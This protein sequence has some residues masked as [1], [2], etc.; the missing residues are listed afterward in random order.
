MSFLPCRLPLTPAKESR[1]ILIMAIALLLT[2]GLLSA[3][4]SDSEPTPQLPTR[5]PVPTFTPTPYV[6]QA[7]PVLAPVSAPA[8]A[9]PVAPVEAAP[10]AVV[11]AAP[12]AQAVEPA[13][14]P[15]LVIV[16]S[17]TVNLRSGPGTD[18]A[19]AGQASRGEELPIV[20]RDAAGE[21]FQVCC[22]NGQEAWIAAFL[23][24]TQGAVEG[25]A[26]AQ[27]IPAPPP[28]SIPAPA[29]PTNTPAPAQPTQPPAPSFAFAKFGNVLPQQNSNPYVTF[30]GALFNK[31]AS[32]IMGGYKMVAEGPAGRVE[33]D[34]GTF[35]LHGNPGLESEYIYNVKIEFP[36]ATPG[37]YKVYVT[38]G[39]GNQV[40]EA[41]EYTVAGETRTFLPRWKQN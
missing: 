22:V 24:E 15:A 28:T 13:P 8:E 5:T 40:A 30:F 34:F 16:T 31:D 38:D 36:G 2:L 26:V 18:Y 1:S 3:C 39:G 6:I 35:P 20:A 17:P 7:T 12:T 23:V 32:A 29:A 21:W 33:G 37:V 11:E 27:N 25:V 14:Q 9:A 19:L 41:Y 10:V 4:G